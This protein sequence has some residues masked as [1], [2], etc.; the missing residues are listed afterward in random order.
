MKLEEGKTYKLNDNESTLYLV[1]ELAEHKA[2]LKRL[3]VENDP[4]P[5]IV[6]HMPDINANGNIE[7][8]S[9]DY[10]SG[11]ANAVNNYANVEELEREHSDSLDFLFENAISAISS[12]TGISISQIQNLPLDIQH[13]LIRTYSE[14]ALANHSQ[15][16]QLLDDVYELSPVEEKNDYL[17]SAEMDLEQNYNQIDGIINNEPPKDEPSTKKA[18]ILERL[19]STPPAKDYNHNGI[20][21]KMEVDM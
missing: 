3:D 18:S 16:K 14:N 9:G 20:D 17:I 4:S 13:D 6:A 8:C 5:Y 10:Y 15:L 11:I 12:L 19:K 21:D 1:I 7:W 2:I